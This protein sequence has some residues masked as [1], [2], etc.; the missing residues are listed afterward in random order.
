MLVIER[1]RKESR[2]SS[3][4]KE[5]TYLQA[6]EKEISRTE[7]RQEAVASDSLNPESFVKVLDKSVIDY[8]GIFISLITSQN[9]Q[10]KFISN[11]SKIRQKPAGHSG[12][13]MGE[14]L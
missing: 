6:L 8:T 7:G 11:T 1:E 4:S 14:K 13:L 9:N 12:M 5:L 2:R 3:R 10:S